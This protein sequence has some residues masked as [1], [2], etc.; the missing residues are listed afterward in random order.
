MKKPFKHTDLSEVRCSYNK[1]AMVNGREGVTGKRL[2][3]NVVARMVEGAR[4]LCYPC[5]IYIKTGRTLR[6]QKEARGKR[7]ADDTQTMNAGA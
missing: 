1:C 7:V 4:P 6:H 2:K 3:K 5:S